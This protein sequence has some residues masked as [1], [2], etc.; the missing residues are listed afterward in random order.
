VLI[1]RQCTNIVN[2]LS[3]QDEAHR[4]APIDLG[5]MPMHC[6]TGRRNTSQI[7]NVGDAVGIIIFRYVL[8]QVWKCGIAFMRSTGTGEEPSNQKHQPKTVKAT[9]HLSS[10]MARHLQGTMAHLIKDI[11]IRA[12]WQL[13]DEMMQL[14]P[15]TSVSTHSRARNLNGPMP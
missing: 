10:K 6:S 15:M 7:S 13:V 1:I 3:T 14:L 4:A 12:M 9:P 5:I 11:G 8:P 2:Q